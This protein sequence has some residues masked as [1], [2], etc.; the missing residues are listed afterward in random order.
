MPWRLKLVRRSAETTEKTAVKNPGA[1]ETM[2]ILPVQSSAWTSDKQLSLLVL[3]G[4]TIGAGY[5]IFRIIRPFLASLF[6]AIIMA[7]TSAPLHKWVSQKIRNR[8]LAAVTTAA[9]VIFAVLIPL[10]VVSAKLSI[11]A[12]SNYRSLLSQL[13]NTAIWSTRLDPVIEKTAEQAGLPPD[14]LKI[15]IA[16]RAR[17]LRTRVVSVAG[18]L[19]QRF[20]QQMVVL[21]LGAVF[22][23]FLV[24]GGDELRRDAVN[25]LPLSP[26]R[27]RELAI[28]VN[29]GV[30]ANIYGMLS[31][32]VAE[33]ILIAIGFRIVGLGTPLIWGAV[34]TVLS[35]LPY[36]GVSLVWIFGCIFLALHEQWLS[37][38]VLCLWGLIVVF[39]ADQV[40]RSWVISGHV[41]TNSLVIQLSLMGGLAVFGPIGIFVGP[42]SV[43]VF[44]SLL[45]MLREEH[46]S[47]RAMR[48]QATLSKEQR[49]MIMK[50]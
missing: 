22:L 25:M 36:V 46:A 20:A 31:V 13:G 10:T 27:T 44:A 39:M 48:D 23:F 33:G 6:I 50:T 45:R 47:I 24:L 3:I 4:L 18:T 35:F 38:V 8:T 26:E 19:A 7:I 43:V 11:E 1:V 14:Q 5:L 12:I 28:A 2:G 34:A 40:I 49:D 30:I 41:K 42:V 9:V 17:N 37:A 32:G 21:L 29:Q 15:E 16:Q